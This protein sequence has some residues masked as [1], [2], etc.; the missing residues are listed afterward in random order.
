MKT[1]HSYSCGTKPGLA[2]SFVL[3]AVLFS[4]ALHGRVLDDFDDNQKSNWVDFTFVP[5]A[6][7]PSEANQQFTFDL[8]GTPQTFK[9]RKGAFA[10]TLTEGCAQT[11]IEG[12]G[13]PVE[14]RRRGRVFV[15]GTNKGGW[16]DHFDFVSY[17]NDVLTLGRK[18]QKSEAKEPRREQV[19]I[20]LGCE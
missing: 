16:S 7:L 1:P 14:C 17:E 19:G 4:F 2:L 5:G 8:T 18:G 12:W 20:W 11:D 15:A 13:E 9:W 6:F 10:V 3:G